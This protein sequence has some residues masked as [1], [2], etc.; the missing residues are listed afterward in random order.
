MGAPDLQAL[1]ASTSPFSDFVMTTG[2]CVL[3]TAID[4]SV[5]LAIFNAVL[6]GVL[7]NARIFYSTGRDGGWHQRI[8]DAFLV[9]HGRFSSPWIATLAAG[10][11]SIAMCRLRPEWLLAITGTG[12]ALIYAA[13]CI[14]AIVGRSTGATDRAVYRMPFYPLWPV[15]GLAA[16]AGVFWT[17]AAGSKE[18]GPPSLIIYAA[19]AIVALG[20]Y[21]II[22]RR[23][24]GFAFRDPDSE[25]GC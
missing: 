9:T 21:A 23:K 18:G 17:G 4:L 13:V 14:A 7:Q 10:I 24:T 19:M 6:A 15:L 25:H 11:A 5:A 2:G 8:N 22:V 20:Y 16:L 3:R 12:I 1:L